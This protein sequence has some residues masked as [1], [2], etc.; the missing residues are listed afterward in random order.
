MKD[1][2]AN[3]GWS[4]VK[5]ESLSN[6]SK[7]A[8]WAPDQN[9]NNVCKGIRVK[10]ACG[11]AAGAFIYSIGILVS[12]LSSNEFPSNDF[13]VIPVKGLS[14]NAHIDPRSEE[15][16]YL[17]LLGGNVPQIHFFEWFYKNVTIPTVK[18]IRKK[19][20]PLSTEPSEAE[21]VPIDQRCIMWG[22]SD[23]PYLKQMTTPQRIEFALKIGILFSI[24]CAKISENTQP[25]DL[26]PFFKILRICGRKMT[27]LGLEKPL[28]IV[29]ELL[30]KKLRDEKIL[31]LP[32][33]KENSLKDLLI[34]APDMMQRAFSE[35]GMIKAFVSAGML[36]EKFHRCPD[37]KK[38][39]ESFK[40]NWDK[41]PGGQ[42]WFLE[43]LPT[44]VGEMFEHGE[45][46][47]EFYDAHYFPMDCDTEG[48]I[49]KLNS[50]ADHLT[51]SKVMYHPAVVE[52]KKEDIRQ[53]LELVRVK[54]LKLHHD[55]CKLLENNQD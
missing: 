6:R 34:T 48:K 39:L 19:L 53:C 28:T 25:L 47:E 29:I 55:A 31:L 44:V 52:K 36:D 10:F 18:N 20:N 32:P 45:V 43:V 14:I 49:W 30:F 41:V 40:V 7:D 33:T 12:G 23:I 37:L 3:N 13:K 50:C 26:G 54:Q 5:N 46:S 16:G 38:I 21:E 51:R 1:D 27:S 42:N 8:V 11:G 24:I 9:N 15:V 4:R 17:C 22:D 35:K 2:H